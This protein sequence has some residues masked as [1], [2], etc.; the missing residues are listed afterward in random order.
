ML[1]MKVNLNTFLNLGVFNFSAHMNTHTHTHTSC[2]IN[3]LKDQ[4][5]RHPTIALLL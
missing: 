4:N 1:V 5:S 3:L 2:N